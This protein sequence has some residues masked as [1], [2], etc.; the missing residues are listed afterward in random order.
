MKKIIRTIAAVAMLIATTTSLA[1][2]LKLATDG[3]PKSLVFEWDAQFADTAIKIEDQNGNIVFSD[4]IVDVDKYV[5]RFDLTQLPQGGYFL[6]VE[7]A[8]RE[9]AYSLNVTKNDVSIVGEK[10]N[11]KPVYRKEDGKVYLSLLNLD[12][13]DVKVSVVDELSRVLFNESFEEESIVE[14]TFNFKDALEGNYTLV[15]ED[16]TS[17]YYEAVSVK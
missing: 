3:T 13:S 12:K 5:K 11:V 9:V 1:N 15:I 4:D 7:N 8:M 14:K 2:E 16:G 17:T 6:K 10:E